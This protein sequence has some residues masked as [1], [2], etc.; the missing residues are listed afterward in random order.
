MIRKES[1][2]FKERYSSVSIKN[3]KQVVSS[4][5][6]QVMEYSDD[7]EESKEGEQVIRYVLIE[8]DVTMLETL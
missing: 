8:G 2:D 6:D 5:D 3:M 1:P 7:E 4:I